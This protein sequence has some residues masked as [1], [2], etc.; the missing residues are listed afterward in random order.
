VKI[1]TGVGAAG[2]EA[3][4]DGWPPP[5][6]DARLAATIGVGGDR[7]RPAREV[8]LSHTGG[9][10]FL[11]NHLYRVEVHEGGEMGA[12][13]FKWSRENGSVALAVRELL[14]AA[15]DSSKT[16]AVVERVERGGGLA[17]KEGDWVEVLGDE[18][19]LMLVPGTMAR[20]EGVDE[21]R[22]I[23]WL[24]GDASSHAD[25]SH[26][27]LRRWDQGGAALP[28]TE[29]IVE[30]EEGVAV[31]FS[32]ETFRTA[33]YWMLPAREAQA[34][35][36]WPARPPRRIRHDYCRLALVTWQKGGNGGWS[37]LVTDCRRRFG[38]FS[39]QPAGAC[40]QCREEFAELR[41][42][43]GEQAR[44]LRELRARLG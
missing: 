37:G 7:L 27:K 32:G 18:S 30:L 44:Q 29:G 11:E 1:L 38:S 9:Y 33:D 2:C 28:V 43:L 12:A 20:V 41:A 21:G 36:D 26:L 34:T 22:Q 10:V 24:D 23:V 15:S 14:P 13:T 6:S 35:V 39:R 4:I 17:L 8:E 16:E 3:P 40:G 25:E 5:T 19:E 31:Q 42:M